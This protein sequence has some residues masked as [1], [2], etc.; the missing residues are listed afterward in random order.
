[1][2]TLLS[3]ITSRC[4]CPERIYRP[5]CG[6]NGKT[7]FNHCQLTCDRV[8]IDHRGPCVKCKCPGIAEPVC[9]QDGKTYSNSCEASCA[10]TLVIYEG[11]CSHVTIQDNIDINLGSGCKCANDYDPVCGINQ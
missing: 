7:Y 6:L 8:K 9:G 11:R 10:N 1:M 2:I 5:I 3:S 4:L